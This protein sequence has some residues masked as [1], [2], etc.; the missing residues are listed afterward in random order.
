MPKGMRQFL[1]GAAATKHQ[2]ILENGLPV[3]MALPSLVY[4]LEEY[5]EDLSKT[6]QNQ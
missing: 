6:E 4:P 2:I 1:P 3:T 5:V